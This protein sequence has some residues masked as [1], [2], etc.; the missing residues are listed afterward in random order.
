MGE[1]GTG[2]AAPAREISVRENGTVEIP[3]GKGGLLQQ[4]LEKKR[5]DVAKHVDLPSFKKKKQTEEVM[6]LWSEST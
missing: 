6:T 2:G 4:T 1:E 5:L 3:Q